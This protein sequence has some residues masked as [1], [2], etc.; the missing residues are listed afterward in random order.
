MGFHT[1]PLGRADELDDPARFRFCSR[2][3]LARA[4]PAAGPVVD[5]GCGTGLYSIAVAPF[6]DR[7][8]GID[9]QPAMLERLVAKGPPDDLAVVAG[10]AASLPL[11]DDAAA[12]VLSTMT[13]HEYASEA[14]HA[15]VRRVLHPDGTLVAVDWS[16]EGSGEAGPPLEE[17][18]DLAG[19]V[20][21]LQA[22]GYHV[23]R[24]DRRPETFLIEAR[25]AADGGG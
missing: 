18:Y 6:V 16:R 13:F 5:L 7:V 22:A 4:L 3:E 17:R 14:A 2:E 19:A 15:E 12:A 1:Y 11:A 25:G 20:D 8:V 10:A 23:V 21:Q 9:L 24:A